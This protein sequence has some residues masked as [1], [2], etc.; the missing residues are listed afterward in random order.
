M[1]KNG[2]TSP[3]TTTDGGS[4][5]PPVDP[6]LSVANETA[7]EGRDKGGK[8]A[9]GA[10]GGPGRPKTIHAAP[11]FDAKPSGG[12][13]KPSAEESPPVETG[14]TPPAFDPFEGM[15]P[16]EPPS[17]PT[18]PAPATDGAG[19]ALPSDFVCPPM[20][21][22]MPRAMEFGWRALA[23]RVARHG[24]RLAY[25]E[26]LDYIERYGEPEGAVSGD[27]SEYDGLPDEVVQILDELDTDAFTLLRRDE[28][29]LPVSD[30]E[31]AALNIL[32]AIREH[33]ANSPQASYWSGIVIR[34]VHEKERK[35]VEATVLA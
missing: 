9:K 2:S 10:P 30:I 31:R 21:P 17:L 7:A 33:G 14:D 20:P 3:E 12:D 26:M 18:S 24:D 8:F 27:G 35:F 29:K 13:A 5:P 4:P 15:A 28:L 22:R 19:E 25:K 11:L 6:A 1:E 16:A 23:H 32:H 34:E